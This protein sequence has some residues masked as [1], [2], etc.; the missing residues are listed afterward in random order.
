[1]KE[2]ALRATWPGPLLGHLHL[3]LLPVQSLKCPVVISGGGDVHTFLYTWTSYGSFERLP[4][5]YP[6]SWWC[7]PDTDSGKGR[8]GQ[9]QFQ[10]PFTGRG[11]WNVPWDSPLS[12]VEYLSTCSLSPT[13]DPSQ[14]FQSQPGAPPPSPPVSE[15]FSGLC[16][17]G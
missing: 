4:S 3:G 7:T 9:V 14:P 6:G 12:P 2:K 13:P 5:P 17:E 15:E 11:L 10:P 1:M 8:M 16:N